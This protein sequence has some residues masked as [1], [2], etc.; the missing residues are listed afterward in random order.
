MSLL[1]CVISSGEGAMLLNFNLQMKKGIHKVLYH[2][3]GKLFATSFCLRWLMEWI[4]YISNFL[5]LIKWTHWADR[6]ETRDRSCSSWRAFYTEKAT[7]L[8]QGISTFNFNSVN[9]S[10]M[11]CIWP[12]VWISYLICQIQA[13][14]ISNRQKSEIR[15]LIQKPSV[16]VKSRRK[17]L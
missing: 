5:Q 14:M 2:W 13:N 3:I 15:T 6:M 12:W 16:G 17:S 8:L 9:R 1:F 11:V 7:G 10:W 4:I